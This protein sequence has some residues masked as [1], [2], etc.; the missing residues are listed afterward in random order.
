MLE[1]YAVAPV[2]RIALCMLCA[3]ELQ[4]HW[5]NW[6]PTRLGLLDCS[7]ASGMA[8]GQ[9]W[10]V[11]SISGLIDS[12]FNRTGTRPDVAALVANCVGRPNLPT[13]PT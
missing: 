10:G 4:P 5:L 6:T 2:S 7:V 3:Q 13:Y 1:S 8:R 9:V 11:A 12:N